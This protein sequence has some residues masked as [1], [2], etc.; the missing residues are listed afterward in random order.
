MPQPTNG[1]VTDESH[2]QTDLEAEGLSS[3][4]RCYCFLRKERLKWFIVGII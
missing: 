3:H 2:R 4:I 1:S